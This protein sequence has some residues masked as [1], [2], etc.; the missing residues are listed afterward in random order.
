MLGVPAIYAAS[1]R[2]CYTDELAAMGLLWKVYGVEYDALCASVREVEELDQSLL[3]QRLAA[4]LEGKPN[5]ADYVVEA[6]ISEAQP[7][8]S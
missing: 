1:D 5:L 3:S 2:R 6:V 8:V 7:G 4:Y